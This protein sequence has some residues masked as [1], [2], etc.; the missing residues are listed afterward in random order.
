MRN[1]V[2]VFNAC[3]VY[4]P[5]MQTLGQALFNEISR[6]S[7]KT[8]YSYSPALFVFSRQL[9]PDVSATAS[10]FMGIPLSNPSHQAEDVAFG[11]LLYGH[12]L[13][14]VTAYIMLRELWMIII[15]YIFSV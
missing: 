7:L 9:E 11:P 13:L 2:Q 3:K 15:G 1:S 8:I 12:C 5:L 10:H 4:R 14:Y 6:A